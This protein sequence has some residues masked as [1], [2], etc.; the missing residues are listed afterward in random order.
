VWGGETTADPE[1]APVGKQAV[2][3]FGTMDTGRMVRVVG[4]ER[5]DGDRET[6][7]RFDMVVIGLSNGKTCR[8]A[9][10]EFHSF[11]FA[12][13]GEPPV[14]ARDISGEVTQELRFDM[15]NVD[16]S[17]AYAEAA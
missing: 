15:F 4:F 5:A 14:L 17:D 7:R 8:I 6:D 11:Q 1:E 10:K 2:V 16:E 3:V 13:T 9:A 12:S